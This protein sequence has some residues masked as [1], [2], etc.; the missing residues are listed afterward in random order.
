MTNALLKSAGLVSIAATLA[1]AA[2]ALAAGTVYVTNQGGG[3]TLLDPVKLAPEQT[4]ELKDN[5]PRGLAVTPD[6]K[7][8]LTAN[9]KL[10]RAAIE[11]RFA[12]LVKGLYEGS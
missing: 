12:D 3:V 6:G 1:A 10:R 11:A 7:Y 9:Q 8:L 5:D 4:I 2:P